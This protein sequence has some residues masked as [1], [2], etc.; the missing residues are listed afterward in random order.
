[1]TDTLWPPIMCP[2][3]SREV[4]GGAGEGCPAQAGGAGV[5]HLHHP[6]PLANL[7]GTLWAATVCLSSI[8]RSE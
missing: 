5:L 3:G 2:E 1:M 7:L 4:L 8:Y 6:A